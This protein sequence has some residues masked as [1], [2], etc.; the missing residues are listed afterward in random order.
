M[1]LA[2]LKKFFELSYF[3][4]Q[5]VVEFQGKVMRNITFFRMQGLQ[6][7]G[8]FGS[9]LIPYFPNISTGSLLIATLRFRWCAICLLI[10]FQLL[11]NRLIAKGSV[12]LWP[13]TK[14]LR[15]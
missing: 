5:L 4:S 6:K 9:G 15:Q 1:T 11:K 14:C 2:E 3:H 12:S 7:L 10:F 8:T 13:R